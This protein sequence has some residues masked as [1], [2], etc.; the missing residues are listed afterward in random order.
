MRYLAIDLGDRRTGVAVGDDAT[1]LVTP[2]AVL[3]APRGPALDTAIDAAILEHRPDALVIGLPINMDGTEGNRAKI[4]RAFGSALADRTDLPIHY[5]DERLTSEAANQ[6]LAR[7]GRTHKQ[8]K[9]VRDAIAAAEILTDFL[10]TNLG[11][12]PG[13]SPATS[14]G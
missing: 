5:Q 7:S 6:R 3:E 1:R 10:T 4:T 12:N 13:T 2:M 8:K 11:T 14:D 9:A